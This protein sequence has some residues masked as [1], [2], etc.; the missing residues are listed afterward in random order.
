MSIGL[1]KELLCDQS[2]M[3][4]LAHLSFTERSF[5]PAGTQIYSQKMI[6]ES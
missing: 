4:E 3:R 2:E 1:E 5:K 6:C